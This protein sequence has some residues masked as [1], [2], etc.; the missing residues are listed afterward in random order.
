MMIKKVK[1]EGLH[2]FFIFVELKVT[3]DQDILWW[4]IFWKIITCKDLFL[5]FQQRK[6]LIPKIGLC[7]KT[8]KV[9][10]KKSD[11]RC[12]ASFTC[13]RIC[14]TNASYFDSCCSRHMTSNQSILVNYKPTFDGVKRRVLS[15]GTLNVEEVPRLK[16]VLYVDGF[17]TN[18]IS[19]SQ[20]LLRKFDP[21][22]HASMLAKY[23]VT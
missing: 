15:K 22:Q 4:W 7:N 9:W 2:P 23:V 5:G 19:I 21:R 11:L 8:K 17:M 12:F 16:N 10:V 1:F 18:L 3:S 20:I 6:T 13:L 14:A